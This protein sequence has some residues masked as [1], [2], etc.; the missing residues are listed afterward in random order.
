MTKSLPFRIRWTDP[1]LQRIVDSLVLLILTGYLLSVFDPRYLFLKTTTAGGDTAS[2]FYTAQYLKDV[3]LPRGRVSGWTQGNLAGFPILQFYFPLPFLLMAGLSVAIPLE[4]AF[5]LVTILG[6]LLLP[7]AAYGMLRLMRCRFPVPSIGAA[8]TLLFLFNEGN[9]MWG[10]NI[11]STLAGEFSYSLGT[12]LALLYL[13]SL[14][15]DL[16]RGRGDRWVLNCLL[17]FFVGFSHGYPLLY[18]GVVSL[19]FLATSPRPLFTLWYLCRVYGCAF[20]LL[21]FWIV[22][23]L[24]FSSYT[25]PYNIVWAL[26]R[27]SEVLP[28][29]MAPAVAV[30]LFATL[31]IVARSLLGSGSGG[32]GGQGA[33]QDGDL[34]GAVLFLWW[35]FAASVPLYLV[36]QHIGVVDIRFV[37]FGQLSLV[38]LAAPCIGF[39][40]RRLRAKAVLAL[41]AAVAILLWVDLNCRSIPHW[42]KWNYEGFERKAAWPQF[43]AVT[44]YLRGTM[45][46]PRVVFEHSPDHDRFGSTRAFESLPLFSGRATLEGVYHQASLSSPFIYYIQSEVSKVASC[47]FP[48]YSYAH[49][50]PA[51]AIADLELFNVGQYIVKSKEAKEAVRATPGYRLQRSFGDY[52]I[53]RVE[54]NQDRYVAPFKHKPACADRGT[55][56]R[57]SFQWFLD[58]GV[59][60]VPV[61]FA[62]RQAC[63]DERFSGVVSGLKDLQERARQSAGAWEEDCSVR[64]SIGNDEI[65]IET[66]C[67]GRP[68]LVKVSYHPNWKVE[69]A[70][71]V[72]LVSPSF[73]LVYPERSRV[74]LHYGRSR[75]DYGGLGMSLLGLAWIFGAALSGRRSRGLPAASPLPRPQVPGRPE[76]GGSAMSAGKKALVV[77]AFTVA[78]AGA[79]V[80]LFEAKQRSP[81]KRFNQAIVLK[82]KGRYEEA[83]RIFEQLSGREPTSSLAL[84]SLY[85]IA[86]THYLEKDY[87]RAAQR[88]QQLSDEFPSSHW[89]PEAQYHIG[90]CLLKKGEV[91]KAKDAFE[92]VVRNYV[93]TVWHGYAQEQLAQLAAPAGRRPAGGV[94]ELYN[95]AIRLFNADRCGEAEPL[96]REIFETHPEYKGA[97]QALACYALCFFKKGRCEETV[98]YYSMLLQRYPADPLAEEA[99]V[100]IERCTQGPAR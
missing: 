92:G 58:R 40:A 27:L 68:L 74:R 63:G 43:E 59:R 20:L 94:D 71:R 100:H 21:G 32:K 55:Y 26:P 52:E 67:I 28:L 95:E 6:T 50:D 98:K 16:V 45:A 56:K 35:A 8:L 38:L 48:Q 7:I 1:L 62:D 5:K 76:R 86:I 29:V 69:G 10:G 96:L 30:S 2:H 15:R 84:D 54:A 11:P 46:D 65:G 97:A 64:E 17:V 81:M 12:A 51:A 49:L 70:D 34:S 22:P 37:P 72:W 80:V 44:A 33:G 82:D 9:S 99:R 78:A 14:H 53:Y 18:V 77:A 47:P 13:G 19:F 57:L 31:F 25:I 66:D 91:A 61:V 85:Y 39:L 83:R 60:G 3:L 90:I 24:A 87:D 41:A 75:A 89:V 4:I 42:V 93:G 79:C 23:L 88:F 73:M 36:A